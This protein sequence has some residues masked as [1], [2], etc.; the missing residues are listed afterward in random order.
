MENSPMSTMGGENAWWRPGPW[1]AFLWG[2]TLAVEGMGASLA[3]S[4][5]GCK[6]HCGWLPTSI[7]RQLVITAHY[8]SV[9]LYYNLVVFLVLLLVIGWG[10][11]KLPLI[12]ANE[13]KKSFWGLLGKMFW[14]SEREKWQISLM[15]WMAKWRDDKIGS[16]MA[17][18][19]PLDQ[20][21]QEPVS[22]LDS[23]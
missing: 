15:I 5:S 13:R 19:E 11:D 23:P 20:L 8:F 12:W 3:I 17:G 22:P 9:L 6:A 4:L 21:T 7:P 18:V 14:S 16:Q 2:L 1:V 10:M